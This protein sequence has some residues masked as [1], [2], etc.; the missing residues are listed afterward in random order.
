MTLSLRHSLLIL[1]SYPHYIFNI[2]KI[3][4]QFLEVFYIKL[5]CFSENAQ[6]S[7]VERVNL[8]MPHLLVTEVSNVVY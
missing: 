1:M 2:N 4:F 8:V 3:D 5:I 6:E 7:I